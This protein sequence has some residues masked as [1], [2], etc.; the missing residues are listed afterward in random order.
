MF[1]YYNK[2][3]G[4]N[5]PATLAVMSVTKQPDINA[6]RTTF[7]IAGLL[8]GANADNPPTI[9]P[10]ELGLAK[11][12]IANVAIAADLSYKRKINKTIVFI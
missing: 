9:I 10:I 12:H 7:V 4:I 11:L 5:K 8:S 2:S 6:L 3:F 1:Q